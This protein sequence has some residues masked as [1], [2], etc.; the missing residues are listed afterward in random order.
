MELLEKRHELLTEELKVLDEIGKSP[1]LLK[2]SGM[3]QRQLATERAAIKHQLADVHSQGFGDVPLHLAGMKEL[4]PGALW[5]GTESQIEAAI[6]TARESGINIKAKPDPQGGK[7]HVE[8]EGRK[9]D[10]EQRFE[11]AEKPYEAKDVGARPV[12]GSKFSGIRGRGEPKP[13]FTEEDVAPLTA[14][15]VEILNLDEKGFR[16]VM[17]TGD[18]RLLITNGSKQIRAKVTIGEPMLQVATHDYKPGAKEVTITISK[19]ANLRDITRATAHEIAEIQTLLVDPN[20]VGPD[21]LVKGST[22]D[23]LSAHDEGRLAELRVLLYELDNDPSAGR[24]DEIRSEIDKLLD[25]VGLNKQKV[26]TDERAKK[27]L[28]PELTKRVDQLAGK[29]LKIKRSQVRTPDPDEKSGHWRLFIVA[30]IPGFKE[31]PMLAQCDVSIDANGLPEGGLSFSIDKRVEHGGSEHR[32]D[33]E[34]IPSLTDFALEEGSKA[35]EKRFGHPPTELPGSLGD[36]NKA[37]FQRA[38]IAE[39]NKGVAPKEAEKLAAAETPF[40]QARAR[41]GYKDLDVKVIATKSLLRGT[42]PQMH[43]VPVTIHVTMRKSK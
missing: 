4:I 30:D 13:T 24:R 34:G 42:P 41:R 11:G 39:I 14:G 28:G 5:S 17:S 31:P 12:P 35:Y 40:V 20:A 33:I 16:N 10:V 18:N 19:E 22:S 25:H 8:I 2:Q 7:W 23:K 36:D 6:H 3:N 43:T 27:V 29:R 15:A 9:I 37:I 32:I 21:A 38:Y 1:E 26:A